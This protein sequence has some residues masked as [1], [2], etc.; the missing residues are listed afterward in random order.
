MTTQRVCN[1][2]L[3]GGFNYFVFLPIPGQMI[4]FDYY[5]IFQMG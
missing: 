2:N 5:D 4:Q 1:F 3:G